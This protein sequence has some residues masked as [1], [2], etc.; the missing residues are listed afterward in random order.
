MS[1]LNKDLEAL[2]GDMGMSVS[3]EAPIAEEQPQEEPVENVQPD[4]QEPVE[5]VQPDVQAE[6]TPE[7]VQGPQ[8]EAAAEEPQSSLQEEEISE[9]EMEAAM[10]SYLSE[11]LGREVSSFDQIQGTQD[12]SVE[13]DERVAAI[14]EFVRQ[15]GR[16]PQD[17]FT[18]QALNPSEMDDVSAVKTQLK[19]QYGDLSDSDLNLLIENKYKLDADLYDDNEVRLSQI[20]LKMDAD[21]A[22]QEIE[23]LRSQYQAPVRQE[24]P[25]QQ[26]EPEG[27]VNDEW[28]NT[29]SAEV[30]ALDGIEFQVS[31]DKA[32][33]FGI[34][35]NY[36]SQLKSKNE[37]I[38][39]F[40]SEYV[41]N[42]GQWDFEKWNMHQ[43]VLDN[44][45]TIVKTAY[46]Q[47]LGE[48]QRGLVDKAANVQYQQPNEATNTGQN[49]PSI[50]DQVRQALGLNDNG[51]TF[52]I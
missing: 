21:K 9:E 30:D 26:E 41:D 42:K 5:N 13:I 6:P 45:E 31:K 18:Y 32:F 23:T 38:E 16:D 12:T 24:Q 52:K 28:L 1:D 36:K 34:E 51:L 14:N 10:L 35:D 33:T 40:F 11:R 27:I 20:Q 8:P 46:Q 29:M 15:T 19:S 43:A 2:V 22:R 4:V 39:D 50:E 44:I 25:V 37:N 48:G 17:W 47:G 7:P 49:V 3:D